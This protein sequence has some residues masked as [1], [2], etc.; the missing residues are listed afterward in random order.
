MATA[1]FKYTGAFV[2]TPGNVRQREVT[3]EDGAAGDITALGSAKVAVIYDADGTTW[4]DKLEILAALEAV[5]RKISRDFGT[6]VAPAD[7]S[8]STEATRE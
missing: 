1:V 8:T 2:S 7:L 5:E 4:A 3:R 6:V